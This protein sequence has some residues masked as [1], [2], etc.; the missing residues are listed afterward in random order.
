MGLSA[1][2]VRF[3]IGLDHNIENTHQGIKQSMQIA[4]IIEAV[5]A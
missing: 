1:G 5:L 2:L 3:S 4:R